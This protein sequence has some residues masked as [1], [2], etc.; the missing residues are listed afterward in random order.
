MATGSTDSYPATDLDVLEHALVSVSE[1]LDR[2]LS[3]V[4]SVLAG[5]VKGD[6]A[7]GRYLMDT[8]GAST[9]ELKRGSFNS[10]LQV[11]TLLR[12]INIHSVTM[13]RLLR[14]RSWYLTSPTLFVR[15]WRS[16]LVWHSPEPRRCT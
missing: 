16:R 12:N 5:Q 13:W 8:F 9:E 2:V 10:S 6:A 14:T 1:M 11:R 7:V 15:K 3:Y 4:R